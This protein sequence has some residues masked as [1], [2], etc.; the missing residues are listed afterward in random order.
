MGVT[1]GRVTT[2]KVSKTTFY[3]NWQ[4]TSQS[5]QNN[6]TYINWQAGINTGTSTSHDDYYKNAVKIYS[7]KINGVTV[8]NGGTWSQIHVGDDYQ[9]LSGSATIPHNADGTKSFTVEIT[10]WTYTNSNYSGSGTFTLDNIP[11]QAT[12]DSVAEFND[13]QNPVLKYT[14]NAGNAVTTLQACIATTESSAET[15]PAVAWRDISKTGNSYTFNLTEAER[16]TLRNATSG[17][18]RNLWFF[19]KTVL[20]GVTYYSYALGKMTI[21]NANPF[22]ELIS[23]SDINPDTTDLTNNDQVIIQG[24]S[25]LQFQF[26]DVEA[27]KG[28]TLASLS[29][30]INGNITTVPF[31]GTSIARTDYTYGEVDVSDNLN[32]IL[33]LT[34][35]RGFSSSYT[36]ALTVWE[37]EQPTAIITVSRVSNFYS[38]SKIKVDAK[39]SSLNNLNTIEIKYRIKKSTDATWD[40]NSWVVI[41]DN[42]E[43]SFTADNLYMWDLQVNLEDA[44]EGTHLYTINGALD[45]GIPLVF[46]DLKKR[47]VGVNTM[48]QESG[49]FEVTGPL[50]LNGKNIEPVTLYYNVNGSNTNITLSDNSANYSYLEVFYFSGDMYGSVKIDTV[51]NKGTITLTKDYNQINIFQIKTMPIT[52]NGTTLQRGTESYLNL[53]YDGTNVINRGTESAIYIYKVLGYQ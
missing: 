31:T 21:V 51:K 18:N 6:E 53:V 5:T 12:A 23:Y 38:E 43:T 40:D 28:A 39:Y 7:V 32:A 30:N 42:V 19:V 10:A 49:S 33:T 35:S 29:I 3:V 26:Y 46:Y 47:S 36:V 22:I 11:R 24:L 25:R 50:I 27:L 17:Q 48:P 41:Q 15:N 34:D 1:S 52:V 13:E 8:S 44:L 45:I 16:T 2:N 14:N 4:Q 37:Y 9:L 20:N